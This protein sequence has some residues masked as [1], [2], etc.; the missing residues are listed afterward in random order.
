M[1]LYENYNESGVEWIP[2]IP[3]NWSI[4]K[5]KFV[6]EISFSSV[7]RH[8]YE[9]ERA[10]S[11][12]H[13]PNAYKN[14]RINS[15]TLLSVGT[16]TES[17]FEKFQLREGQVIITKDSESANDIGI[18][19]Y[20]EETAENGVCGYHLAILTSNEHRLIGEFL[21]RYLQTKSVGSFFETNSNGVTRF[22]LGKPIIENLPVIIPSIEEQTRITKFLSQ[23]ATL[24]DNL[25][26]KKEQLI[27]KLKEQR[28][29]I[30]NETVT[31]GLNPNVQMKD[32][33]VAW[34]G[35][36]PEH[37]KVAK[38][39]FLTR[40]IV[41]GAHFTPTYVESG[42]PFLRVTDIQ[43]KEIDLSKV[44]FI[45][46][47]EHIELSKRCKPERGDILLSKNG[48]I[49]ITK[50]VD[51]DWEF[52]LFVSLCLIKLNKK[53]ESSYFSYFFSSSIVDE[54]VKIGSKTTSV[55]NLHLDKIK[56]LLIAFPT[57]NFEQ[58]EISNYLVKKMEEIDHLIFE[59][60]TSIKRLNSYRQSLISEAVTGKIDVRDWQVPTNN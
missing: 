56:E 28:Q 19:T 51:W 8:E 39:K 45:P 7:D 17:E 58:I 23:K 43:Q 30:I 34:L 26:T 20:V 35:D 46:L 50:V 36:I 37:W 48:T 59:I 53:L 44:K 55:T 9:S 14:E 33:G 40:K 57:S 4:I 3:S 31:K 52:S 11:I 54:Q 29:A 12:C 25:I 22:G 2:Q 6:A 5:L 60:E 41:D 42:V 21:F 27:E 38:M 1:K 47:S 13:Y 16:C 10:V 32:S 49:G 15:S 18:P 24:I